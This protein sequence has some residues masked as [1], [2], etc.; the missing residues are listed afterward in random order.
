MCELK[1]FH[2]FTFE[3]DGNECFIDEALTELEANIISQHYERIKDFLNYH[4]IDVS[5]NEL[6]TG[7]PTNSLEEKRKKDK[8][9]HEAYMALSEE[10]KIRRAIIRAEMIKK[11]PEFIE[12]VFDNASKTPRIKYYQEVSKD[13]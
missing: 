5:I 6:Y 2:R 13:V 7:L 8:A 11:M 10:E 4:G 9:E 12:T 3:Y 1:Y